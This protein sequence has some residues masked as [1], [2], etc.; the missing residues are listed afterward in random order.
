M[1][2]IGSEIRDAANSPRICEHRGSNSETH[3][4]SQRLELHAEFG[5]GAGHTGD[6]A[7]QRIENDGDANGLCSVVK[8]VRS[9]H[10]RG[11]HRV[12]PAKQISG[13][14]R[15]RQQKNSTTQ[16][17]LRAMS[18]TFVWNFLLIED[19]HAQD[20][21]SAAANEAWPDEFAAFFGQRAR[22][23]VPP[24][25]VP[26]TFTR[27]SEPCRTQMSSREQQRTSP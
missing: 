27:S 3:Y 5:V 20:C 26:P 8:I 14:H 4:V 22:T 15:R 11:N 6:T 7:I 10:E 1:Q 16:P 13:S 24:A 18:A 21:L 2:R 25:P 19:R 23:T 12:V 17:G 9:P